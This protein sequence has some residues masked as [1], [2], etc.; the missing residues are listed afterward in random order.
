MLSFETNGLGRGEQVLKLSRWQMML[1]GCLIFLIT[2]GYTFFSLLISVD[3]K[4]SES[5]FEINEKVATNVGW[6][7]VCF[8]NLGFQFKFFWKSR[9]LWFRLFRKFQNEGTSSPS[10]FGYFQNGFF[11]K[12]PQS[13]GN[14]Q[15]ITSSF[16]KGYMTGSYFFKNC[17]YISA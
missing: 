11:F 9:N 10:F 1:L 4:V 7:S 16:I 2:C 8:N 12:K 17:G 15:K 14:F 3:W 6:L 13:T 5:S